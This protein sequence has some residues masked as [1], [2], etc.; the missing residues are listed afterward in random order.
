MT[1]RFL[2]FYI[3][4]FNTAALSAEE[5]KQAQPPNIVLISIDTL[6]SD[7]LGAY[8]YARKTSP[9]LDSLAEEGV[10]FENAIAESPWTLPSHVT[11]MSGQRPSSHGVI[12]QRDRISSS[13]VLLAE[14]L[15]RSGYATYGFADGAFLRPRYGF[16]RGFDRYESERK[17]TAYQIER[18]KSALSTR[19][20][21]KPFFLFLH[22][23][24]VHCPYNPP[25]PFFGTFES[26]N[27]KAVHVKGKCGDD[28]HPEK[29]TAAE[30]QFVSDRYDDGIRWVDHQLAEFFD[31]LKKE[32]IYEKTAIVVTSD[33]GEELFERGHFGHKKT[34]HQQVLRI[35][36]IIRV[37]GHKAQRLMV[38]AGLSNVSPTI[39]DI[40]FAPS[41][42]KVS[43]QSLYCLLQEQPCRGEHDAFRI[44]ELDRHIALRSVIKD[45]Y[46]LIYSPQE[47]AAK[48][49]N[50]KKDEK[51]LIDLHNEKQE[52]AAALM[53]II[54]EHSHFSRVDDDDAAASQ[55]SAIA[56]ELEA[57]GYM[58]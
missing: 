2:L 8:G 42:E 12:L 55:E 13:T 36:L 24:D 33:H 35:P 50:M 47:K 53:K 32:K 49:F 4:L 40:A 31:Y 3:L 52:I 27:A 16:D 18:A 20:P 51:E 10:V 14:Q 39:L 5:G 46:H 34:L 22:T 17:G 23:Y 28:F 48:L 54:L 19:K 30:A 57:L 26:K 1:Y 56:E 58:Q 29:M 44:S 11:M 37:P 6:R 45:Q 38:P 21:N 41:L 25:E 9:T 43:G 7:R 15:Q